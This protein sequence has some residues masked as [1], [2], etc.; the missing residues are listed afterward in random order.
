MTQDLDDAPDIGGI[1]AVTLMIR[2]IGG[3]GTIYVPSAVFSDMMIEKIYS[4]LGR[5]WYRDEAKK[6]RLSDALIKFTVDNAKVPSLMHI[7]NYVKNT[8]LESP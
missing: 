2:S 3:F 6:K 5:K 1:G 4:K 8:F 7:E